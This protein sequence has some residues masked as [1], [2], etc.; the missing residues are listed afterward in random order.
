MMRARPDASFVVSDLSTTL[1]PARASSRV[2]K[3][4]KIPLASIIRA[5]NE[6]L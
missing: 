3:V 5:M 2:L 4:T 1:S 6:M